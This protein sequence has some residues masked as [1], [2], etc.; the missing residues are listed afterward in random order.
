[1]R[2]VVLALAVL[3]A[4]LA[5]R[6]EPARACSCV[7]GD[8]R[9]ALARA[10][11]A[12]VGTLVERRGPADPRSSVEPVTLVF[13]VERAVKGRL[14]ARVEVQTVASGASCGIELEVGARTGLF[15]DRRGSRWHGSL[16]GQIEPARLLEAARPLPAPTGRGPA[17][18]LAG[19]AFGP[20]RTIALDRLGR[21]IAYGRGAGETQLLAACPGSRRVAEVVSSPS[22]WSLA[23]RELKR[24]RVVRQRPL[25]GPG[26][27]SPAAVGCASAD[28]ADA[29]VLLA[30]LDFPARTRLVRAGPTALT[31]AWR[32]TATAASFAGRSAYLNRGPSGRDVAR[33]ELA[34]GRVAALGRVPAWTGPLAPSPDGRLLA[35]VSSG[36]RLAAR[37]PRARLVLLDRTRR[38]VRTAPLVA[39]ATGAT[40]WLGNARVAFL[41]GGEPQEARIYDRSLRLRARIRPWQARQGV[42]AGA[43]AYG[44]GWQGE[45]TRAQLPAGPV[46]R[47][48][49]LPGPV[50]HALIAVR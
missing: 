13:R 5:A 46:R 4:V 8:P 37:P 38:S 33:L 3:A 50:V 15:L 49:T 40:A 12:F 41:P 20:A 6:V 36:D 1:M 28:G 43:S 22:G 35:G 48:R 34:S 14:G 9:A 45:L 26:A 21:T 2:A 47:L 18:L 24:M 44:V 31:T 30:N 10:D 11:A 39:G 32:G 19:G 17:V 7:L 25:P 16:C 27:T 42:V 29:Y 23:I